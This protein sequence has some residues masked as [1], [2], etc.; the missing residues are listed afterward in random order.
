MGVRREALEAAFAEAEKDEKDEITTTEE[1]PVVETPIV[2]EKPEGD[3]YQKEAEAAAA[4]AAA[5]PE[6]EKPVVQP[7]GQAPEGEKS[8][9]AADAAPVSWKSEEKAHWA[10]VPPEVKAI[11]Q[12]REQEV[13][14]A[15]NNTAHARKF[16]GEFQQVVAPF[17]HL[18]RA[19]NSHPLQAVHNLMQTAAG[20]MTGNQQ[21]KAAIVAEIISNYGVDLQTLDTT[22][23][24]SAQQPNPNA[25]Q[26]SIPPQFAQALQP[27]YQFMETIQ[28]SRQTY[29]QQQAAKAAE[30][31]QT[32]GTTHPFFEEVRED[33][34]DLME[35]AA[36]RGR[37]LSLEDAYKTAIAG[38]PQYASAVKQNTDAASVSAAAAT[39]ARARN[40]A[41]SVSGGPRGGAGGTKT[42]A[43]RRGAIEAAWDEKSH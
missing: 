1:K 6:G 43:T 25:G 5:R 20:L 12:R 24:G 16:T 35:M 41:S 38:N 26:G 42:P 9:V 18:I 2:E 8:P 34:A 14:R 21:Q 31:I 40:A 28:Q 32:F 11:I 36:K 15:L 27:I 10:K 29:E 22:L 17:A 30:D 4:A 33:M 23:A 3:A 37:K 39:L 19:Q 7:E 13:Q